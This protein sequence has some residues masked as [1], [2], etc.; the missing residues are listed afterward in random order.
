M[1]QIITIPKYPKWD[2]IETEIE[3][4]ENTGIWPS[5]IIPEWAQTVANICHCYTAS[6][7]VIEFGLKE[8]IRQLKG[9]INET[10]V[11]N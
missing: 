4:L 1:T 2:Q 6:S 5:G 7:V 9:K 10:A 11:G 3:I 8:I